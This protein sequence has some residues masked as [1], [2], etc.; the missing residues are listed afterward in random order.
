M[1]ICRFKPVQPQ[2]HVAPGHVA[3]RVAEGGVGGQLG[4]PHHSAQLVD[5]QQGA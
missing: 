3:V 2:N 5:R 4:L 1:A